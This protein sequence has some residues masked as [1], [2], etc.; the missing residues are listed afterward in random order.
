MPKSQAMLAALTI[1][2]TATDRQKGYMNWVSFELRVTGTIIAR[3]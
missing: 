1:T 2:T 3:I